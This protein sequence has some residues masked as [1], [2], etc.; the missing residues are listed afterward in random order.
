MNRSW[1]LGVNLLDY[2]G[3]QTVITCSLQL[4]TYNDLASLFHNS[5]HNRFNTFHHYILHS[6]LHITFH[7]Y[8]FLY[9]IKCYV[10]KR[11]QYAR[12]TTYEFTDA[13]TCIS[14]LNLLNWIQYEQGKQ[15][16][17][18]SFYLQSALDTRRSCLGFGQQASKLF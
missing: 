13:C 18:H 4:Q 11:K 16:T 15:Q 14:H 17:G 12:S 1:I 7:Y 2:T 5:N 6:L 3:T 9:I 8:R 10:P